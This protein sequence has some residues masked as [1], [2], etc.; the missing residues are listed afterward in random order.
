MPPSGFEPETS[1]FPDLLGERNSQLCYSG[2]RY[3]L[4]DQFLW[5]MI[6]ALVFP[7]TF[8]VLVKQ[9]FLFLIFKPQC[10]NDISVTKDDIYSLSARLQG[11]MVGSHAHVILYEPDTTESEHV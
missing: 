5:L 7:T 6:L 3:C 9:L 8:L 4:L 10:I 11:E 2:I 1:P